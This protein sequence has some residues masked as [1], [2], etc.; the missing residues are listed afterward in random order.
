MM[1]SEVTREGRVFAQYC[2]DGPALESMM[3]N[4]RQEFEA[5]PPVTGAFTPK[6][7]LLFFFIFN[8]DYVLDMIV[9][10]QNSFC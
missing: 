2:S 9:L 4:L 5:R 6:R 3:D 8:F 7:G 1:I 10:K